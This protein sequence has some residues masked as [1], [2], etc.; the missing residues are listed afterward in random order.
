MKRHD[1]GKKSEDLALA[2]LRKL[3]HKPV[4]RNVRSRIGEVDLV[5][6]DK[7]TLVFTEVRAKSGLSHGSPEETIDR[8]KQS[9]IKKVAETYLYRKGWEDREV[10]FDVVTLVWDGEA[11]DLS[12]YKDA[13]R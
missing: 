3:R 13:F 6:L 10:R 4:D 1:L 7:K 9:R 12:Y 2:Y 11:Y 5:T 8:R